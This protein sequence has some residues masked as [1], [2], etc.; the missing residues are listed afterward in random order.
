[1]A[2]YAKMARDTTRRRKTLQRELA[3]AKRAAGACESELAVLEQIIAALKGVEPGAGRRGAK[4]GRRGGKRGPKRGRR[5]GGKWRQGHPGRPPKWWVE[6]QKGKAK[7]G[8]GGR[9][10]R[11]GGR[12][13]RR[14]GRRAAAAPAPAAPAPQAAG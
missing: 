7:A 1:M 13:G 6:Q 4:A 5:R 12:R 10:R 3:A 14:P 2:D 9:K 8:K 11:S